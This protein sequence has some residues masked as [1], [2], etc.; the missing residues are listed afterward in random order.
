MTCPRCQADN[1]DEARFCREC[2]ET[3]SAV[4]SAC[5]AKVGDWKQVLR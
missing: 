4:C 3:L 2:G 1:R 5:G